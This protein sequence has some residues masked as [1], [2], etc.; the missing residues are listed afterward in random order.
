M[1]GDV[2]DCAAHE[3]DAAASI[4][5]RFTAACD[6]SNGTIGAHYLQRELERHSRLNGPLDRGG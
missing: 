6:G 2:M 5:L 1:L 3:H 4:E